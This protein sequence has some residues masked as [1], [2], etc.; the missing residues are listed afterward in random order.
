MFIPKNLSRYLSNET[1]QGVVFLNRSSRKR[2]R[3]TRF[4]D[5]VLMALKE[6]V[7]KTIKDHAKT[8]DPIV[9]WKNGKVI[10][11]SAKKVKN[12]KPC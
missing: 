5:L 9:I 6:A 3:I 10:K 12:P 1:P 2:K 8:N 11:I 7:Y 4:A